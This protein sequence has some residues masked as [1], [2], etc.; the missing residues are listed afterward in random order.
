[1]F[2]HWLEYNTVCIPNVDRQVLEIL[3]ENLFSHALL[4]NL[5]DIELKEEK[6]IFL[7]GIF[8]FEFTVTVK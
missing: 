2:V 1:M 5:K 7:I 3:L 6:N 4:D 8:K